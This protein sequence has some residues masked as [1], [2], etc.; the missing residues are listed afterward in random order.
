MPSSFSLTKLT[1]YQ[2]KY[3][4]IEHFYG[5]FAP[6]LKHQSIAWIYEMLGA[7]VISSK[8]TELKEA[9]ARSLRTNKNISKTHGTSTMGG[10]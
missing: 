1:F 10:F 5:R 6:V 9:S 8:L 4:I 7:I 3:L 2:T